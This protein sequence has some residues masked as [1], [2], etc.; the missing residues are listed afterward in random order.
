VGLTIFPEASGSGLPTAD[1]LRS[2]LATTVTYNNVDT[3][4]D[5]ALSVTVVAGGIYDIELMVHSDS[6]NIALN[7]DFGGTATVT[8]FIGEW[9]GA[10]ANAVFA[11]VPARVTAPGTD[12]T[13]VALGGDP[14]FLTFDGTIEVDAGGTFLLRGAQETAEANDTTILR[15]STLTLTKL[16]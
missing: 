10:N 16:N 4:A 1:L 14:N 8:N 15:G 7:L 5:T 12:Y 13:N 6:A 11:V 2:Y 3:L 9:R